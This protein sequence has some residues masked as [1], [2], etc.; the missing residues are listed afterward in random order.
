MEALRNED[1]WL[2][3]NGAGRKAAVCGTTLR[4]EPLRLGTT[5]LFFMTPERLVAG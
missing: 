5:N 1:W 4:F 3:K 2:V